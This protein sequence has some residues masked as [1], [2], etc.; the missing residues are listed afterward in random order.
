[1]DPFVV[2]SAA[3]ALTT[4]LRLATGVCLVVQRD[5]IQTAKLVA[6]IDQISAGRFLF[7]VG[8]GWTNRASIRALET[9]IGPSVDPLGFRAN[10]YFE[11]GRGRTR[12]P[13]ARPRGH[14]PRALYRRPRRQPQP[15]RRRDRN[16]GE[17]C[18]P[19]HNEADYALQLVSGSR[20]SQKATRTRPAGVPNFWPICAV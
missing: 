17:C 8:G 10:I 4:K 1:M 3:A 6:S 18:S 12:R 7:G 14:S 19:H 13:A 5:P 15:A 11:P 20:W 16:R 2:L 9:A